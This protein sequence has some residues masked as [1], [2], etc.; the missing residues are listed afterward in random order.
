M[1]DILPSPVVPS[2]VPLTDELKTAQAAGRKIFENLK[3]SP[4]RDS[5]LSALG[6]LGKSSL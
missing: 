1:F 6:R 3:T 5:I 2:D 4:E